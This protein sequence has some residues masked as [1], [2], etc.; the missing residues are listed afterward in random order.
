MLTSGVVD[1]VASREGDKLSSCR[2]KASSTSDLDLS[3]LR[4]HLLH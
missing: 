1:A 2:G 3:T 4:I